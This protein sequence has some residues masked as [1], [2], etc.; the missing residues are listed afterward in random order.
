MSGRDIR[1]GVFALADS[2]A[3]RLRHLG[4]KCYTIQV[5]VKDTNLKVITHQKT[6]H[7]PTF[8]SDDIAK[9]A[10]ELIDEC[11]RIGKPIRMLT[12]TA[13]N[14]IPAG[15]AVEQLSFFDTPDGKS[16]GKK[17]E[18]LEKALDQIRGKYGKH[19]I[20]RGSI[21]DNDL[22]IDQ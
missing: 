8:L 5:T 15:Q 7:I 13:G 6:L 22:G 20:Q 12:V 4:M 1:T 10:L 21:L 2:V 19:S 18:N 17:T 11:W 16:E 14:L 9:T 3:R